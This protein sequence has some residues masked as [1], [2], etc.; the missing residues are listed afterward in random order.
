MNNDNLN[1]FF[2]VIIP[3]FNREK[4]VLR[5]LKSVLEQTYTSFEVILVND[6][7]TDNGFELVEEYLSNLKLQLRKKVLHLNLGK[8]Y[9]VSYARN[10]A[11]K[12]SRGVYLSFLDSDD[13]FLPQKLQ[14][15]A[16]YLERNPEFQIVHGNEQWI[17]NGKPLNQL[18]KHAKGGGDQ[19]LPSLKLCC[20]SPSCV[21][22]QKSLFWLNG[23]FRED[24][25]V[26]EDYDLW[27]K[28]T[29]KHKVGFIEE[30]I[31]IKYGGHEDQ[32]S[33]KY[34]AMDFY[35]IK[36]LEWIKRKIDKENETVRYCS[37]EE[38][39]LKKLS[40]LYKG[41]IKHNNT[42]LIQQIQCSSVSDYLT[43]TPW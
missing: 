39:L 43:Q 15:Q 16:D 29:S 4:F 24:Y 23:G 3:Y 20:I 42:K 17:R 12:N 33:Q 26:C 32:L 9:G 30:P 41:A 6:G 36:S 38:E 18:K 25:P 11:V 19:F 35:R 34:F 7:S 13:E 31:I 28:I 27:L 22:I 14:F 40:R 5:A 37:I 8:N 1:P 2:S 10:I 21:V